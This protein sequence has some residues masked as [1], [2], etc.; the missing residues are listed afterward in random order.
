ME[1]PGKQYTEESLTLQ[2][3]DEFEAD[4]RFINGGYSSYKDSV[5]NLFIISPQ[6]NKISH[7]Y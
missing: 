3:S 2:E 5:E 6:I 4:C 7:G 1:H